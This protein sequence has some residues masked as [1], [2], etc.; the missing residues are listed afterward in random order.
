MLRPHRAA[1]L[2]FAALLAASTAAAADA[3]PSNATNSTA[4]PPKAPRTVKP[5]TDYGANCTKNE[6]CQ[7]S[8]CATACTARSFTPFDRTK[9]VCSCPGSTP[10]C[11]GCVS[12]AASQ[13]AT[14]A[15]V[16]ACQPGDAAPV[17]SEGG[18]RA[19][20]DDDIDYFYA[21][22]VEAGALT[23]ASVLWGDAAGV[24]R[25]RIHDGAQNAGGKPFGALCSDGGE[26]ASAICTN[27][28]ECDEQ[29]EGHC[30]CLSAT[31]LIAQSCA[32]C[33][34]GPKSPDFKPNDTTVGA[35]PPGVEVDTLSNATVWVPAS[36]TARVTPGYC[37]ILQLVARDKKWAGYVPFQPPACDAGAGAKVGAAFK[38]A[39]AS[40][41][42]SVKE[43]YAKLLKLLCTWKPPGG[44]KLSSCA[45]GTY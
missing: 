37:T 9:C 39:N 42:A 41:P 7:S 40:D 27:S 14:S 22:L 12:S 19:L 35:C 16:V 43:L 26:C 11:C 5:I 13:G 30:T 15:S 3:K 25:E 32:G 2:A 18:L 21:R 31:T 17:G 20:P 33:V 24:I 38:A 8:V 29:L 34:W 36:P 1:I 10:C 45:A 28:C 4:A 6:D 44:A 23:E